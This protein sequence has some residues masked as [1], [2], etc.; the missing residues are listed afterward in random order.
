MRAR[1][2]ERERA[3]EKES[4][5]ESEGQKK[6]E[7]ESEGEIHL[8]AEVAPGDREDDASRERHADPEH[9][10]ESRPFHVPSRLV[11]PGFTTSHVL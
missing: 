3:R 1:K 7:R 4:E 8:V 2:R 10:P 11:T 9:V 5:R 6:R